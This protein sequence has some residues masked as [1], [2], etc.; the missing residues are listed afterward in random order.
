[1]LKRTML[2]AVILMGALGFAAS[3]ANAK[4]GS[5]VPFFGWTEMHWQ[6]QDFQPYLEPAKLPHDTQWDFDDW[7]SGDWYQQRKDKMDLIEG[8]Y[9]A[10]IIR[11][12]YVDRGVP[13]LEIGPNF[14]NLGGFDK[15]RVA[16]VI[17]ETYNIT[18]SK[19][20]GM[21]MLYDWKTHKPIGSYTAYGL[22]LR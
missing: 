5:K 10:D 17:D 21:F 15:R 13:V 19:T 18:A 16:E 8:F 22:Q 12:Q 4:G 6:D 14:Y 9:K 3:S 20:F 11:N 1:M 2:S 7:K